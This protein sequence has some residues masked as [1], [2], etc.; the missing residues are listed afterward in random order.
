MALEGLEGVQVEPCAVM[1]CGPP[2][3]GVWR[4]GISSG[5]IINLVGDLGPLLPLP[6]FSFFFFFFNM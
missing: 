6:G 5:P 2:G 1:V 4:S 3:R